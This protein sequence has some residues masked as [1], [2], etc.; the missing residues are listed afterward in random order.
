MGSSFYVFTKGDKMRKYIPFILFS[1]GAVISVID[2]S[3]S[4]V[5]VAKKWRG[6]NEL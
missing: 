4:G 3:Y 5:K 6:G 1:A 2:T